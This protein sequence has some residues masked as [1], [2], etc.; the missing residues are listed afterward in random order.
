M[1]AREIFPIMNHVIEALPASR[2]FC[3]EIGMEGKR[4]A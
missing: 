1:A 3:G 2:V 4:T